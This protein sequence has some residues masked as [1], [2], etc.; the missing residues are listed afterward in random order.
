MVISN[1]SIFALTNKQTDAHTHIPIH[2]DARINNTENN[3]TSAL[4]L[5]VALL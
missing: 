2:I 1:V 3:T 4:S 5:Y